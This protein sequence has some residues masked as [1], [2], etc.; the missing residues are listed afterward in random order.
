[1]NP[2]VI[3]TIPFDADEEWKI[4]HKRY[5]AE[6]KAQDPDV[7]LIGASIIQLIQC[8]PIWNDKFVPL[9]SL[10]FGICG[11]RTQDVLWRVKNGILDHIKPKVC[12][13]NVGS[14]NVDNTPIQISE[15]ILAIV[16]EIRSKLPDCYIII[17]GILPRGPYPNPLRILG[18]QVNAIVSE[19]V[20]NTFKVELF[21]AHLLQPDGTL[22]QEDTPDYLHPSEIGYYKIFN[23]I[24][25]RLKKILDN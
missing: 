20:K 9:K 12:I 16:D 14:N 4:Q 11:D 8:Y 18:T 13:L 1:M 22:S 25:E 7:I 2:C 6:A 15:G 17:I 5:V 23:P 21:N 10:N 19:K 24:F 3:P